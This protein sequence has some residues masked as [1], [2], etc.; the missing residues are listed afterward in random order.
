M[1]VVYTTS[2]NPDQDKTLEVRA[3]AVNSAL[4]K[5]FS[6][7]G[8]DLEEVG[9]TLVLGR[10]AYYI[11]V[12][13]CLAVI[14]AASVPEHAGSRLNPWTVLKNAGSL[15]YAAVT[16]QWQP[17]FASAKRLLTDPALVGTLLAGFGVAA[18]LAYYVRYRRSL[19]FSRFWHESRQE[20]REALKAARE[21]MQ[22]DQS[23]TS[24]VSVQKGEHEPGLLQLN[25]VLQN[26]PS[27][28]NPQI[29]VAPRRG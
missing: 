26:V 19:V 2:G 8:A 1:R 21:R 17:L 9:N 22:A 13:S 27:K 16:M 3:E 4:A 15:I 6:N 24:Q 29:E 28:P 5:A 25:P 7:R 14:L 23:V 20:L 11:Y 10:L 18:A 12:A